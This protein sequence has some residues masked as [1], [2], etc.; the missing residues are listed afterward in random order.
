MHWY[1]SLAYL[2]LLVL[3][4][5]LRVLSITGHA[6]LPTTT[7]VTTAT[8]TTTTPT[9]WIDKS[10]AFSFSFWKYVYSHDYMH[11]RD[12]IPCFSRVYV[13]TVIV[14]TYYYRTMEL[15]HHSPCIFPLATTIL[16][17][18]INGFVSLIS[19]VP[20]VLCFCVS[21]IWIN[22]IMSFIF[23]Y[24]FNFAWPCSKYIHVT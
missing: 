22:S 18:G 23:F 19:Y 12:M 13:I 8:A 10:S 15:F 9:P 16:W 4:P 11:F 3:I 20:A 17:P 2:I 6:P 7:T 5:E 14:L 24:L 1:L 21:F